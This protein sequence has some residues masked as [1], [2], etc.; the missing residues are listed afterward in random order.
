VALEKVSAPDEAEPSTPTVAAAEPSD[1]TGVLPEPPSVALVPG[2]DPADTSEIVLARLE[3]VHRLLAEVTTV[4]Q[5]KAAVA[6]AKAFEIYAR[7]TKTSADILRL[8]FRFKSL[9]KRR[10]GEMVVKMK[11]AG[12]LEGQGGDRKSKSP[13]GT[14]KLKD[15]GISKKESVRAQEFASVSEQEF[16]RMLGDAGSL[17]DAAL[18]RRIRAAKAKTVPSTKTPSTATLPGQSAGP[19]S[20]KTQVVLASSAL[21]KLLAGW[22]LTD[23]ASLKEAARGNERLVGGLERL[24]RNLDGLVKTLRG[25][26]AIA[27]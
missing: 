12:E 20:L 1:E 14:L 4:P 15:L 18:L 16:E 25:Y 7:E 3:N 21:D 6:A 11:E 9:A 10:L 23:L 24:E 8:A 5:A 19:A 26:R 27:S 17:S 22:K 13:A 2:V